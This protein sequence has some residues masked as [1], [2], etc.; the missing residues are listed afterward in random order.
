MFFPLIKNS[1]SNTLKT[2]SSKIYFGNA[3]IKQPELKWLQFSWW[4]LGV[5]IGNK[6][7][8]SSVFFTLPVKC[9]A[10]CRALFKLSV[11]PCFRIKRTIGPLSGKR[12]YHLWQSA[13]LP[14]A[15]SMFG[16]RAVI[17]IIVKRFAATWTLDRTVMYLTLYKLS[18]LLLR[19]TK[20]D[21]SL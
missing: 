6:T 14:R 15:K 18:P 9:P 13:K 2:A 11:L 12:Q 4:T 7:F 21:I 3:D 1:Y 17:I 20:Q 16:E 5:T 10:G 19:R 8:F